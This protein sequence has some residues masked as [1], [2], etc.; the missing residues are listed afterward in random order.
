MSW[1][2]TNPVAVGAPTK[3]SHY[4]ALWDNCD[5]FKD[6]HETTGTHKHQALN[7]PGT[8]V[9]WPSETPPAGWLEC[10]GAAVSRATYAA[11][12]AVTGDTFG[13][14]DGSTTF[15]LPDLRGKFRRG[16]DHG[17]GYDPDAATRTDSGDGTVGD[18]VGTK[19]ADALESHDH[20][21]AGAYNAGL[22]GSTDRFTEWDGTGSANTIASSLTG[23]NETRPVNVGFMVIIK[24]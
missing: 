8:I 2:V 7:A 11:L 6:E 1:T 13:V 3:K 19:Q 22:G 20:V 21:T 9:D 15:N 14:G 16:W 10:N 18:H 24:Y 23:G 5:E 12:F 17:A 4:D